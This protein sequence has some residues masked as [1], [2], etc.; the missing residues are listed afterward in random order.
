MSKSS[1]A[2]EFYPAYTGNYTKGRTKKISKIT[3]H[4]MAGK[5][6]AKQCG[7]IFQT[8]GRK[9]SSNYGIG[10]DGTIASYVDEADT[11][12]CDA[13]WNSNCKSVTIET[14][15]S[16]AGGNWEVSDASLNSLIKLVADIAKRNNFGT[17]VKGTNVTWHSMYANTSCPGS[18]LL[19]KMDYIVSEANKLL[20]GTNTSGSSQNSS[21]T[22]QNASNGIVSTIQKWFNDNYSNVF[23]TIA[24]DNSFGPDTKKHL[25]MALQQE[26]N[27]QYG[28][29]LDRD[30]SF[31]PASKSAFLDLKQGVSGNI[32]RI[33]QAFLYKKGYN[34]NGFD[35][36]F[37][38]GMKSAVIQYQRDKGLKVDG[39]IGRETSYN[40]FN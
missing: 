7:Q 22:S 5:L 21:N 37:G 40:L 17:L 1:L 24:V 26:M 11:S 2:T 16:K 4:H 28:V 30:G 18:Y 32:T 14:S 6:T 9:A 12:W 38:P 15:N 3:I 39:I 31:G 8:K 20:R 25:I 36:S 27:K 19:S 33:C 23:G 29:K 35:G 10:Y 13:N 34:P